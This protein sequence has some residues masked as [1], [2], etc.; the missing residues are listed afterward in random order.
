MAQVV[1]SQVKTALLEAVARGR[2][3]VHPLEVRPHKRSTGGDSAALDLAKGLVV[4]EVQYRTEEGPQGWVPLTVM[5]PESQPS[6]P[7]PAV[8]FL[9]A[10]GSSRAAMA[11]RQVEYARSGYVTAAIDCRYHGQRIPEDEPDKRGYYQQSLVRAWREGPERPFL[12]DSVWDLL[13]LLDY[14]EARPDVDAKRIGMTGISLG[15]M[16]TWLTAVADERVAVAAPMIGVQGFKWAVEHASFQARVDSIPALFQA[17]AQ[18]LGAPGV[19]LGVVAAVWD[20]LLPGLLTEYDA[21]ASLPC[22]APR[23]LLV[24]NGEV[25]PR[26]PLPGV[27]AALAAAQVAY[28][29]AGAPER[30]RLFVDP[31]VGHQNTPAMDA[32]IR[33]WMDRWLLGAGQ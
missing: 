2:S 3:R 1:K 7:L 4:E 17:A 13:H 5:R 6:L 27:K 29:E 16:H 21:P 28:E 8:V 26:C 20:K 32:E 31:G 23:P 25:D 14:L 18:D 22:I 19:D 24:A 11:G 12:L 9:H 10:T 30:L 15:G 33:R